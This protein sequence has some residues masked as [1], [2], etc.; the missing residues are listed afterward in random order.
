MEQRYH[1]VPINLDEI[2][3]GRI[4]VYHEGKENRAIVKIIS[5]RTDE[6]QKAFVVRVLQ[7]HNGNFPKSVFRVVITRT[8]ALDQSFHQLVGM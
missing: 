4:L 3:K 6:E 7:V 8:N 5:V 2:K 1:E